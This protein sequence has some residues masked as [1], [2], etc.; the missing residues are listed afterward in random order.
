MEKMTA[1]SKVYQKSLNVFLCKSGEI[2]IK[3]KKKANSDLQKRKAN[4]VRFETI[5]QTA[6]IDMSDKCGAELYWLDGWKPSDLSLDYP[7][8]SQTVEFTASFVYPGHHV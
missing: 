2:F 7:S 1:L 4:S 5:V 6:K 3:K 8:C